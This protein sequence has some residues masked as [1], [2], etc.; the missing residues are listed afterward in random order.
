[1]LTRN[2]WPNYQTA[3]PYSLFGTREETEVQNGNQ[4][5]SQ[6]S[7]SKPTHTQPFR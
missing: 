6:A 2:I 5:S 7:P 4:E 3:L 1:M